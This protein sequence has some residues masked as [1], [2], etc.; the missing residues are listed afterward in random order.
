MGIEWIAAAWKSAMIVF[1]TLWK[2]ARQL[3]HE[4]TGTLFALFAVSGV[5]ALWRQWTGPRIHWLL[6]ATI[7]YVLMMALFA[8]TSFRSARRVR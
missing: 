4:M 8:W 2:A 6:A 7:L 3:F 5:L 1:R